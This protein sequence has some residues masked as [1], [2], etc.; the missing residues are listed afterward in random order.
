MVKDYQ[1]QCRTGA[2]VVHGVDLNVVWS[3]CLPVLYFVPER[4][5]SAWHFPELE[6]WDYS[7]YFAAG[8]LFEVLLFEPDYWWFA[9]WCLPAQSLTVHLPEY[10]TGE[11]AHHVVDL[12]SLPHCFVLL[13]VIQLF[14]FQ[15]AGPVRYLP[16]KVV[17]EREAEPEPVGFVPNLVWPG[18]RK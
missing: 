18:C 9:V 7:L 8:W 14:H 15:Q 5:S 16:K 17:A 12:T 6:R 4:D 1:R 11:R 3:R 2:R 10:R 13:Q